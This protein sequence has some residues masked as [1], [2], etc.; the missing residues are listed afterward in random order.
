MSNITSIEKRFYIEYQ[1][2]GTI[3]YH[4]ILFPNTHVIFE[5]Y[6]TYRKM[7]FRNR[8]VV[9][10]SNGL[11]HLS[12]PLERGRNQRVAMKD[13]RISYSGRWQSDH[14]R[15]IESCYSRAPFFPFYRE[16]VYALIHSKHTFLLDLNQDILH[17]LIS[18]LGHEMEVQGAETILHSSPDGLID[19][20][21]QFLPKN[22]QDGAM[23]IHYLQVFGDRI[24][25]QPNVCILDLLF[26][27]GPEAIKLLTSNKLTI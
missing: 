18:I 22:F 11:V 7:S 8:C 25:F 13:V 3:S 19:L 17:W 14:W 24:G 21:D 27:T 5:Q 9:A 4:M 26:C 10:G 16:A 6:D 15:T 20:R 12:V 2:F 23:Q 1:Y